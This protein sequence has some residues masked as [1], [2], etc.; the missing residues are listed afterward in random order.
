MSSQFSSMNPTSYLGVRPLNPGNIFF[1]NRDPNNLQDVN[2]YQ[3]GDTWMNPVLNRIWMLMRDFNVVGGGKQAVWV[4][5]TGGGG[6]SGIQ[7]LKGDVGDVVGPV[8]GLC[9][10]DGDPV[11]G[12][13]TTG[14]I[15]NEITISVENATAGVDVAHAQKGVSCFNSADFTVVGG[16]VSST[17]GN[18]NMD[19]L[20]TDD[21]HVVLPDG[22][23]NI[24][25]LT[26]ANQG[27]NTIGNIA[28]HTVTVN[29]ANATAGTALTAT[30][31][32]AAFN[33]TNFTVVNGF[34]STIAG[35]AG[36]QTV[37]GN[38]NV[39]VGPDITGNLKL[40]GNTTQ[41]I[42]VDGV[43]LTNTSTIT[44]YNATTGGGKGVSTYTASQFNVAAGLVSL[45]GKNPTL[46]IFCAN[47]DN[48]INVTGDNTPYTV[49]F[50]N[51]EFDQLGNFDGISTFT[52]S[53][54]GIYLFGTTTAFTGPFA[55]AQNKFDVFIVVNGYGY[56]VSTGDS[57]QMSSGY[58]F[59]KFFSCK[60]VQ[61]AVGDT[62]SVAVTVYGGAKDITYQ[63]SFGNFWGFLVC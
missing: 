60:L 55:P 52:A 13:I 5:I 62:V 12:V 44:A 31:G 26:T 32:V 42:E 34:V 56:Y 40:L 15:P 63:G 51:E 18:G 43:A 38:D 57:Y 8:G 53:V 2:N 33:S 17:G 61:L 49:Q 6:G 24:N 10:I 23:G 48:Q 11:A 20:T 54:A 29:A 41:G 37:K 7:N 21:G 47:A 50:V 22:A 30:K 46:P 1:R 59:L 35:A 28:G 39:V 36:I 3:P 19:S 58:D 9:L 45:T 16:F 25:V 14:I 27:L 4:Q